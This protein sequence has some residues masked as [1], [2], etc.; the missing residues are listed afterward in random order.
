MDLGLHQRL[1]L[2][3]VA[4][5]F[6][7]SEKAYASLTEVEKTYAVV[8]EE[9]DEKPSSHTQVWNYIQFLSS[10]G[11]IRNRVTTSGGRSTQISLPSIPATE[12]EKQLSASF[13]EN[14]IV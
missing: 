7:D 1:F 11:I 10:I 2:L 12:L 5:Y 14:G 4:R 13:E 9:F 3:A 8:C 6:K